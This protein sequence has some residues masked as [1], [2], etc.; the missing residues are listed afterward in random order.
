MKLGVFLK[1]FKHFENLID[2]TVLLFFVIFWVGLLGFSGTLTSGYHLTDNHE[3][4]NIDHGLKSEG[5]ITTLINTEKY[6]FQYRFAPLTFF[7]RVLSIQIFHL[8][9]IH[10]SI[11]WLIVTIFSSL[12]LYKSSY[13]FGFNSLTSLAFPLLIQIGPQAVLSWKLGL[14]ETW[15]L[16]FL[17]ISIYFFSKFFKSGNK[18]FD[19][20][21]L[22][23][24]ILSAACKESFFVFGFI[25]FCVRI[26]LLANKH[27]LTILGEIK[28]SKLI[29]SL[30]L[31]YYL[32]HF[33]IALIVIG[34]YKI[35]G[36]FK[37]EINIIKW[38]GFLRRDLSIK[39]IIFGLILFLASRYTRTK[40]SKNIVEILNLVQIFL[41]GFTI[42]FTQLL[43]Y[44][45]LGIS[46]RYYI[47]ISIGTTIIITYILNLL[48]SMKLF[49]Y[50]FLC[51]I[52][53]GITRQ[54]IVAYNMAEEFTSEGIN[55]NNWIREAFRR[56]DEQSNFLLVTEPLVYSEWNNSTRIYFN[57]VGNRKN[58]YTIEAATSSGLEKL[59]KDGPLLQSYINT[60]NDLFK[61]MKFRDLSEKPSIDCIL[62]FPD[63]EKDFLSRNADWFKISDFEKYSAGDFVLYAKK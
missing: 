55:S 34:T 27:N 3:F 40:S 4:V 32:F 6:Y 18:R 44:S 50:I 16:L 28:E 54:T 8:N 24:L 41:F 31:L 29:I 19:I 63:L 1:N 47:P 48:K 37:A 43:I 42:I 51:L 60:Y 23:F 33:Y 61:G 9:F 39:I 15:G 35:P 59:Y 17:S 2:V 49:Y 21:F 12:L 36:A 20:L 56:T 7:M 57:L 46:E 22:V 5:F 62:L 10:L 53:S 38:L 30:F 14:G 52:I 13:N 25:L 26:L 58:I 45:N 11:L